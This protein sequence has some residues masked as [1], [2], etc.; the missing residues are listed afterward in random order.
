MLRHEKR[1]GILGRSG[2]SGNGHSTRHIDDDDDDDDAIGNMRAR[3]NA[4]NT[5]SASCALVCEPPWQI[6]QLLG[7][8]P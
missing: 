4:S 6:K 1:P 7:T 5:S 3:K 8:P 2:C